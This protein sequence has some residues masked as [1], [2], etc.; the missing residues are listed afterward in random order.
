MLAS[1]H[2]RCDTVLAGD[3][4]RRRHLRRQLMDPLRDRRGGAAHALPNGFSRPQVWASDTS[5]GSGAWRYRGPHRSRAPREPPQRR[6]QSFRTLASARQRPIRTNWF[7]R[8]LGAGD[9]RLERSLLV[10]CAVIW[11]TICW[12][13]VTALAGLLIYAP[14]AA[15]RPGGRL[16]DL[17]GWFLSALRRWRWRDRP[18]S[19]SKQPVGE[20]AVGRF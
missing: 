19:R 18:H 5:S 14:Q 4:A 12:F 7:L 16:T 3:G 9:T 6:H 2:P 11:R 20:R 13:T 8:R 15:W 17:R 10:Q 1:P